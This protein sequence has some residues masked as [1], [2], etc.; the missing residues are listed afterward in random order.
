[1]L[2]MRKLVLFLNLLYRI[3]CLNP[4]GKSTND[5][6]GVDISLVKQVFRRT[7]AGSFINSGTV[8]VDEGISVDVRYI[9]RQIRQWDQHCI[10]D[11]RLLIGCLITDIDE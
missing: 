1:M 10:G 6:I 11:M 5:G 2:C 4:I 8:R 7:G 9:V 3:A